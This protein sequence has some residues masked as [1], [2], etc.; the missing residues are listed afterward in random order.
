[1]GQPIRPHQCTCP[2]P[3]GAL[4][5][6]HTCPT[7]IQ[8]YNKRGREKFLDEKKEKFDKRVSQLSPADF[9]V[10]AQNFWYF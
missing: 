3:N 6:S 7:L 8:L 5:Y 1:M 2:N 10:T 9:N 4:L